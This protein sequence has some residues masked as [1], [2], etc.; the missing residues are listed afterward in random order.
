MAG[1]VSHR[2]CSSHSCACSFENQQYANQ[3]TDHVSRYTRLNVY[4]TWLS[5]FLLDTTTITSSTAASPAATPSA[6]VAPTMSATSLTQKPVGAG[7]DEVGMAVNMAMAGMSMSSATAS[8]CEGGPMTCPPG[9]SMGTSMGV[10]MM[11]ME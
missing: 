9:M 5:Q 11:D 4:W 3:R 7:I 6:S 2:P 10:S 8:A 1:G